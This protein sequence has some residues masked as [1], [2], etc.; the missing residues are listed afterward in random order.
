MRLISKLKRRKTDKKFFN[1]KKFK[2]KGILYGNKQEVK[3]VKN[4]VRNYYYS[5]TVTEI[6]N[7]PINRLTFNKSL[8]AVIGGLTSEGPDLVLD[9]QAHQSNSLRGHPLSKRQKVELG[10][11]L[12][13]H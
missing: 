6:N 12:E 1:K 11:R 7:G 3:K 8:K 5:P 4:L 9:L 13:R 2:I 10:P